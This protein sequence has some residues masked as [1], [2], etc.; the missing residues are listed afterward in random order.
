M[1]FDIVWAPEAVD[2]L[3]TVKAN[4]RAAVRSALETHLRHQPL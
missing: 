3:K 4:S 2:D 1:P